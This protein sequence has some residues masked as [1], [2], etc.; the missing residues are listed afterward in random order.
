MS[1]GRMGDIDDDKDTF[2]EFNREFELMDN[3][4]L[5]TFQR[6]AV[7]TAVTTAIMADLYRSSHLGLA[8]VETTVCKHF[9]MFGR[10]TT[11]CSAANFVYAG[12]ISVMC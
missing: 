6:L 1:V 5:A 11:T 2:D 12:R 10:G 8:T 7:L 3:N 9:S 4:Q